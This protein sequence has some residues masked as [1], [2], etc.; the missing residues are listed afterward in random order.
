[1]D[2]NILNNLSDNLDVLDIEETLTRV[3]VTAK[4][5]KNED[6]CPH[7]EQVSNKIHQRFIKWIQDLPINKKDTLIRLKVRIFRCDNA[8]CNHFSFTEQF[9]FVRPSEK[10]TQR[11]IDLILELSKEF[12]CREVASILNKDGVVI[13][14]ATVNNIYRK[15]K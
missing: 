3:V 12:G 7:C 15:Y 9:D 5:S 6:T 10:K 13:S 8:N 1:M 11:L 2:E 14:K 4:S